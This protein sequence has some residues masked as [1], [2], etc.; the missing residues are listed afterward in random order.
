MRRIVFRRGNLPRLRAPF[1]K[2]YG[3]GN[4]EGGKS[5][6][7]IS[8][9]ARSFDQLDQTNY[10]FRLRV[11]STLI[12]PS[13]KVRVLTGF[14]PERCNEEFRVPGLACN[15]RQCIEARKARGFIPTNRLRP[16]FTHGS[17]NQ[18]IEARRSR[19]MRQISSYDFNRADR[20]RTQLR[21]LAAFGW[22]TRSV[23]E[24]SQAAGAIWPGARGATSR[25]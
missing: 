14:A 4:I 15:L 3:E 1:S 23:F 7:V 20:C 8:R 18:A 13:T 17:S 24:S 5:L 2:D 16:L 10:L 25:P 11:G 6:P 19:A 12:A 9:V 22:R 21:L